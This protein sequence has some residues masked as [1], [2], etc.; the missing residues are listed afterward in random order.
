MWTRIS[1]YYFWLAFPPFQSSKPTPNIHREFALMCGSPAPGRDFY[2]RP[3]YFIWY[4]HNW[5]RGREKSTH[6]LWNKTLFFVFHLVNLKAF[7]VVLVNLE[8]TDSRTVGDL[9]AMLGKPRGCAAKISSQSPHLQLS[10]AKCL[11]G[12]PLR[13]GSRF[14]DSDGL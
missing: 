5:G 1:T 6:K 9:G 2:T 10:I 3:I 11:R 8:N 14:E 4:R 13:S 12:A 7:P